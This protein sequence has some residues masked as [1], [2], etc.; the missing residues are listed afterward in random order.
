MIAPWLPI[1][2]Y[3]ATKYTALCAGSSPKT[4]HLRWRRRKEPQTFSKSFGG[5]SAWL[6]PHTPLKV[7]FSTVYLELVSGHVPSALAINGGKLV[8]KRFPVPINVRL[9]QMMKKML[10]A[11]QF[12]GAH[13]EIIVASLWRG[14]FGIWKSCYKA[15]SKLYQCYTE[16]LL[17]KDL[18]II[19]FKEKTSIIFHR[20]A[21]RQVSRIFSHQRS[22]GEG[23]NV[24]I[25]Q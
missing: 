18:Y 2:H 25:F 1:P 19:T 10:V 7:F 14:H 17:P 21:K 23:P 22:S 15:I 13:H 11:V 3:N 9:K 24:K 12:V 5:A 4:Q 16:S 20:S 8:P 6:T